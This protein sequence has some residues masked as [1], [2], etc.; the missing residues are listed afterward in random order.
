[1]LH[2]WIIDNGK[3]GPFAADL[4]KAVQRALTGRS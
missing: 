2:V 4:D 3:N 1:M